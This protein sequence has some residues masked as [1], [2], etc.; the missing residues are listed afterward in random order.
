MKKT[1]V[2]NLQTWG[3]A[4]V[5]RSLNAHAEVLNSLPV[6][7]RQRYYTLMDEEI[8][9]GV[10]RSERQVFALIVT[11]AQEAGLLS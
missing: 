6:E 9:P 7:Y 4:R 8:R 2:D 10:T 3:W 1:T 11:E 5:G